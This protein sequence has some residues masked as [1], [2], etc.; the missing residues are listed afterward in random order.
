MILAGLAA[1]YWRTHAIGAVGW[2]N[3]LILGRAANTQRGTNCIG[4][5]AALRL[6]ILSRGAHSTRIDLESHAKVGAGCL[7]LCS[8][9]NDLSAAERVLG[10]LHLREVDSSLDHRIL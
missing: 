2:G 4:K 6:F 1:A 3:R 5:L 7:I 10:A 8:R 9:I